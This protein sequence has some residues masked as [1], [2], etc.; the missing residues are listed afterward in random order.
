[1]NKLCFHVFSDLLTKSSPSRIVNLTSIAHKWGRVNIEDIKRARKEGS[2]LTDPEY[3][4]TK[5]AIVLFTKELHRKLLGTS[6]YFFFFTFSGHLG[7]CVQGEHCPPNIV[8][9]VRSP[10]HA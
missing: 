8:R 10:R 4:A 1:M 7:L 2:E 3:M 6:K 9:C 5:L